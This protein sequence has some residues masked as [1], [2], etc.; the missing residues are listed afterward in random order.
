[1][2]EEAQNVERDN[3]AQKRTSGDWIS[4]GVFAVA[5]LFLL[6]VLIVPKFAGPILVLFVI[7]VVVL[8]FFAVTFILMSG[9]AQKA[10]MPLK[11]T[12]EAS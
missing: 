1:M 3:V 6:A 12:F 9:P 5:M 4:V 10:K 7:F 11:Q 2:N 8:V